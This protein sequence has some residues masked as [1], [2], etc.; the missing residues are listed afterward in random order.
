MGVTPSP[1]ATITEE[2]IQTYA[3]SQ[4]LHEA[5]KAVLPGGVT[6][7]A[8]TFD[9]FPIYIDRCQGAHKWDVE[10]NRYIDYWMGHGA[11]LAC[12]SLGH[13]IGIGAIQGLAA[14]G[15]L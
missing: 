3:Q 15:V 5:S 9:P 4:H 14:T 2:Y 10:D 8:R 11:M 1:T 6:H 7:M 13:A 12:T